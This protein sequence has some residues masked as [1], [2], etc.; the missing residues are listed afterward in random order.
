MLTHDADMT[1][2]EQTEYNPGQLISVEDIPDRYVKYFR[3]GK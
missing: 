3:N 1:C 2:K